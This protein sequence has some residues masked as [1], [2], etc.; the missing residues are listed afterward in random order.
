MDLPEI[1]NFNLGMRKEEVYTV[2]QLNREIRT[3]LEERYPAIWVEGE[4]SN[5]KHH[6]SGH[7]Y[8]TLKDEK[9]QIN[10]VFFS[11]KHR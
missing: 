2:S 1:S 3:I 4:I 6:S 11:H 7:I 10:A 5:F 8:L 9:S